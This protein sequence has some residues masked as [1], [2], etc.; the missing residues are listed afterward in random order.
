ME[1]IEN[2]TFDELRVGDSA[3]LVR[4]LTQHDIELFAVMS[5]DVNPAH[6]DEAFAQSDVFHVLGA[7]VPI[8]L[9]SRADKT[10]SRMASCALVLLLARHQQ[11]VRVAP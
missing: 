3:S 10:L 7:R 1:Y 5:G 6:V 4:G 11:R 8:M 9:T 2:R